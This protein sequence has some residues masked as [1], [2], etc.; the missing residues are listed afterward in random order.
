MYHFWASVLVYWVS[1][2]VRISHICYFLPTNDCRTF[3]RNVITSAGGA[4][5]RNANCLSDKVPLLVNQRVGLIDPDTPQTD[6]VLW[7]TDANGKKLKLVVSVEGFISVGSANAHSS[8]MSSTQMDEHSMK[9]TTPTGRQWIS[10][11]VLLKI[12]NGTIQ[13]RSQLPMGL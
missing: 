2:L 4:C 7:K 10:G 3:A 11:M 12:W 13:M 5:A 1:T 8:P 9:A 6:D